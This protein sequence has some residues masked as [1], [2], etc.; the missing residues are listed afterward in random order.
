MSGLLW[1]TSSPAFFSIRRTS[2]LFT[3]GLSGSIRTDALK[4]LSRSIRQAPSCSFSASSWV[5]GLLH[6]KFSQM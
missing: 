2:A 4:L 6:A 5:I 1:V 3:F